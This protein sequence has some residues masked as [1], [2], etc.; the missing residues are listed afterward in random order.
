MQLELQHRIIESIREHRTNFSGSDAKFALSLGISSSQ[1][2][3]IMK[4]DIER[5][6][7]DANW[8]RSAKLE[9]KNNFPFSTFNFQLNIV[10][11][12]II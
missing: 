12:Q 5:V 4:G 11:L 8:I 7:S 2:S 9:R 6:L 3:R 1:Y 10:S